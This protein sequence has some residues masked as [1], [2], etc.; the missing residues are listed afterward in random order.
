MTDNTLVI[1][2]PRES[3]EESYVVD[4]DNLQPLPFL[5][6]CVCF[7]KLDSVGGIQLRVHLFLNPSLPP[8]LLSFFPEC[9]HW[10]KECCVIVFI[11]SLHEPL[12]QKQK[13]F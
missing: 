1:A 4:L 13:E 5:S 7:L 8:L 12:W 9:W 6:D 2:K 3:G 10:G 11:S